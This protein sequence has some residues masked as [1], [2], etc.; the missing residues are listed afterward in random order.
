MFHTD[1]LYSMT[2]QITAEYIIHTCFM[3]KFQNKAV[4]LNNTFNAVL[5]FL[6]SVSDIFFI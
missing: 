5:F 4:N 2:D 1:T 6:L 3:N